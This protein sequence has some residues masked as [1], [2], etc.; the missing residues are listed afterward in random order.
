MNKPTAQSIYVAPSN[1][2]CAI[3]SFFTKRSL[4]FSIQMVR[5]VLAGMAKKFFLK[6]SSEPLC[7]AESWSN[8][9]LNAFWGTRAVATA[10]WQLSTGS[11]RLS[12]SRRCRYPSRRVFRGR[13]FGNKS[14][15]G[16]RRRSQT[17]GG[18]VTTDGRNAAPAHS[19]TF[20][21]ALRRRARKRQRPPRAMKA[22][23]AI[24]IDEGSGTAAVSMVIVPA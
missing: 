8:F 20:N 22:V 18:A 9:A 5:N 16:F 24:I 1:T 23:E 13:N 10:N 12:A 7:A 11:Q 4:D 6:N 14:P 3:S 19:C 15:P 21:Y 17:A 2:I